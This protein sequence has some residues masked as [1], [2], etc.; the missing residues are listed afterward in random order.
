MRD[1]LAV[2][3]FVVHEVVEVEPTSSDEESDGEGEV[4]GGWYV[5]E[6]GERGGEEEGGDGTERV[7]EENVSMNSNEIVAEREYRAEGG[8]YGAEELARFANGGKER[9]G[10]GRVCSI[11]PE[12]NREG[13]DFYGVD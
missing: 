6:G 2:Q 10:G 5:K 11:S 12:K 7:Y 3:D 1:Q 4:E 8:E 9:G 13:G